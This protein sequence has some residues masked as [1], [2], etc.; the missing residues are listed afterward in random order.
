MKLHKLTNHVQL[1]F[2]RPILSDN[3]TKSSNIVLKDT[4]TH[5][6]CQDATGTLCVFGTKFVFKNIALGSVIISVT[7]KR[8]FDGDLH[9]VGLG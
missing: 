8:L 1:I 3:D 4:K 5:F 2:P 7:V 9:A 6:E